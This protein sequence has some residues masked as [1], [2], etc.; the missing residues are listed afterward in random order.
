MRRANG[1][2]SIFITGAASGMGRET[3]KLFADKGWFVGGYDVNEAGLKAL[4]V[5]I[6]A[7]NCVVRRLDVTDRQDYRAALAAFGEATDGQLDLLFNNA[8]IGRGGPFA[9]QPFEDVI[10]VVQVNLMGV[11]IG[12]HEG[13]GLL[14]AT[15]NSLCFTTSSSSATFGMAGIAVY[16]ATKHAVKGLSEALS[17]EFKAYG[18]RVADVLPGLIDTPILPP[19]AIANAPKEGLFRA[20]APVEVAK[21]VWEAYHADTLHWYV[22]PELVEMDKMATAAP[23]AMRDQMAAGGLFNRPQGD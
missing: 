6:G 3:A 19:E 16:S 17:V 18:V 13:I 11:L 20:I 10:A 5:E 23:E 9:D 1:R 4:E 15:P 8:G 14:K 22:P 21:V 2:K 7:G 12:I